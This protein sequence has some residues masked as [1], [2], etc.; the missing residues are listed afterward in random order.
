M[1]KLKAVKIEPSIQEGT[2]LTAS[3]RGETST[4]LVPSPPVNITPPLV[5]GG[6]YIPGTVHCDPGRWSGFPYPTFS[7]RWFASTSDG[8]VTEYLLRYRQAELPL[9]LIL[10]GYQV[11]CRV[12]AVNKYGSV[13]HLRTTNLVVPTLT[14]DLSIT[15]IENLLLTGLSTDDYNTVYEAP[16]ISVQGVAGAGLNAFESATT[17]VTGIGTE[18]FVTLR[19][20]DIY[21][22]VGLP[23]PKWSSLLSQDTLGVS[24]EKPQP[25]QN[26]V[27]TRLPIKNANA[28]FGLLGWTKVGDV[29]FISPGFEGQ[30]AFHGGFNVHPMGSNTPY[31]YIYQDVPM[32]AVWNAGIDTGNA[33]LNI[34]WRQ[35]I[36]NH[37][38]SD[39]ANI[40]VEFRNSTG[41]VIGSNAGPGLWSSPVDQWF[42]RETNSISV[43]K[44]TRSIR[45]YYEFQWDTA[46]MDEDSSA[47][48]DNVNAFMHLGALHTARSAGGPDYTR[49]RIFWTEAGTYSGVS[50]REIEFR[51]APSGLDLTEDGTA[52]AGSTS[53]VPRV[54][55]A[56]PFD[57]ILDDKYW[58][59]ALNAVP[60]GL[61]T[62]GYEK[63]EKW[64][65]QEVAIQAHV[66][67]WHWQMGREFVI[68]ASN[69]GVVWDN[70]E[71]FNGWRLR[72]NN[73][74]VHRL[75][76][77]PPWFPS[78]NRAFPIHVGEMP[79]IFDK[80]VGNFAHVTEQGG[81]TYTASG[82][83]FH[84]LCRF[85]MTHIR[86]LTQNRAFTY[87]W[88][89][90][91]VFGD[92]SEPEYFGNVGQLEA[93]GEETV[94]ID[95][96]DK[97]VWRE[98]ALPAPFKANVN[99]SFLI[100][101]IVES[102]VNPLTYIWGE[103]WNSFIGQNGYNT[104]RT[105]GSAKIQAWIMNRSDFY[106]LQD[107][108]PGPVGVGGPLGNYVI[109]YKGTYY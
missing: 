69:D 8:Q 85:D 39:Q 11:L 53:G 10:Q 93:S 77:D 17:L 61:A 35:Y 45:V 107:T 68:Q 30:F 7:Y 104:L 80:N 73:S 86:F 40:R 65:P 24:Y 64:R 32:D 27:Q 109:D 15:E 74:N 44:L 22:I 83:V 20:S 43:P 1:I 100:T 95:G 16:V 84:S 41:T 28:E 29:G 46:H 92:N 108:N 12:D 52:F 3:T 54:S 79:Y 97:Y 78:E 9:D 75:E 49:W 38:G 60:H 91:R 33:F 2:L 71:G 57:G 21:P 56:A 88:Q 26:N 76:T 87:K 70:V 58:A 36:T 18:D 81:G 67:P 63:D 19:E 90:A 14:P 98:V 105:G 37:V 4:P 103:G 99:D 25:L 102:G 106:A 13:T 55:A 34:S 101:L 48:I 50:L 89:L 42:E 47:R 6:P 96:T 23:Q 62:I 72:L 66:A 5:I 94:T 82:I 31:T 59:G 51:V